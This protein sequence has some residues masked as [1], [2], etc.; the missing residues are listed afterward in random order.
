MVRKKKEMRVKLLFPPSDKKYAKRRPGY[1]RR[2]S[3]PQTAHAVLSAWLRKHS[4]KKVLVEAISDQKPTDDGF[5]DRTLE[6]MKG[7]ALGADIVGLTCWYHNIE[8][9]ISLSRKIK[10]DNLG[11]KIALGGPGISNPMIAKLILRKSQDVDFVIEGD[12]EEALTGL[13]E[14]RTTDNIPN[15]WYRDGNNTRFTYHQSTDLSQMPTWDFSDTLDYERLLEPHTRL[16]GNEQSMIGI[17]GNRG[18]P[19]ANRSKP[20]IFCSSNIGGTKIRIMPP[21]MFW[22]QKKRLHEV[23]GIMDTYCSDNVFTL[24]LK[25]IE[26]IADEKDK[27]CDSLRMRVYSYPTDIIR[28]GGIALAEKLKEIGVYNVFFGIE[29]FSK[30]VNLR[31]NKDT[32]DLAELKKAVEILRSVGIGTT[33]SLIVGLPGESN[34]SLSTTERAFEELMSG[35]GNNGIQRAYISLGMPLIGTAW[36]NEL[37]SDEGIRRAYLQATGN[38]LGEELSIR[39]DI[40]RKLSIEEHTSLS[41]MHEAYSAAGRLV[42]IAQNYLPE[43]N[44]GGYGLEELSHH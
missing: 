25:H 30:E 34:S 29:N 35:Y 2:P 28:K 44:V 13:V 38:P 23:H 6:E 43:E 42:R 1:S 24:S 18:C 4:E 32:F 12:G 9:V 19:K 41:G 21:E 17:F 14:R 33:V 27:D 31:A 40:L 11:T 16:M 3:P 5:E 26:K 37:F 8:N 39:Y 15:L 36:Y 10:R 22:K 20:C 7:F